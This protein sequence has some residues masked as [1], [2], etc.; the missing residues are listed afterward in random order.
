MME[1]ESISKL[2]PVIVLLILGT[3]EAV[4]GLYF[5]DKRSKN[6]ITIELVCLT[7]L[8]TLIQPG[9]LALV[10][11]TMDSWFIVYEDILLILIFMACV[12]VSYS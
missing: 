6:D 8:P 11:F 10:L 5:H 1:Q 9:I 12:G 2:I 4:G 7:I 3:I